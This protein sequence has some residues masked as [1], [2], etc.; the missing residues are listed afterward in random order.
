MIR[1]ESHETQEYV[2]ERRI[3]DDLSQ[4]EA[5]EI[6]CVPS[7]LSEPRGAIHWCDNRCSE[8][9]LR[10]TQIASMVTEEGG[11]ARTTNSCRPRY[12]E[13]LFQQGKQSLNVEEC[14]E[15]DC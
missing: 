8:T 15:T 10:C 9:S 14:R 5:D 13:R 3:C 4:E 2:R 7:A 11:E 6:G 1:A 12:N